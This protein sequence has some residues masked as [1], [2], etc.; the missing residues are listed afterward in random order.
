MCVISGAQSQIFKINLSAQEN[1]V[2]NLALCKIWFIMN[3]F[4]LEIGVLEILQRGSY[5]YSQDWG[6]GHSVVKVK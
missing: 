6:F 5:K 2:S 1:K 4:A 3:W